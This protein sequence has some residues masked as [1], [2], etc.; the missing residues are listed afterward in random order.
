VGSQIQASTANLTIEHLFPFTGHRN[1]LLDRNILHRDI[2]LGNIMF[3]ADGDSGNT[4][5]LIDLDMAKVITF[6]PAKMTE[7]DTRTVRTTQ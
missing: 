3:D 2:S 4:G 7:G 6:P 5:R 1:L